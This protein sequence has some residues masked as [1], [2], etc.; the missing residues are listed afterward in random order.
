MGKDIIWNP[1]CISIPKDMKP[2]YH[3]FILYLTVLLSGCS[4]LTQSITN[5]PLS[6]PEHN[7][8]GVIYESKGEINLA[9]TEYKRAIEKDKDYAAPYFN[10]GNIYLKQGLYDEAERYYLLAVKKSP[11][12]GMFYNNL[13]WLYIYGRNDL[14]R[15]ERFAKDAVKFDP[16]NQ[17]I[18]FDTLGVIYTYKKDFKAGED[19]FLNALN[20]VSSEDVSS[21]SHI[22]SHMIDM[23][24]K[25]GDEKNFED[26][27]EKLKNLNPA[28]NHF[29]R[30]PYH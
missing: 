29:Y 12:N 7:Q 24:A 23:Y 5:A 4:S 25:N 1:A 11:S 3:I 15:A 28:K 10:L 6:A 30:S 20:A 26:T 9:V 2:L 14:D 16:S 21:L 17:H 19:A 13:A 8:L 18:Y 22:Y 27:R